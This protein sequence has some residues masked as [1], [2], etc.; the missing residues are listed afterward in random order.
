MCA[1]FV[2]TGGHRYWNTVDLVV[3][4]TRIHERNGI[5]R[6]VIQV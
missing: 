2:Q 3:R 5:S 6:M 4:G 1:C